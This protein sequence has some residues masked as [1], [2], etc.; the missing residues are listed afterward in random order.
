MSLA[1]AH[2]ACKQRG[3]DSNPGL[4]S[5][6]MLYH[7]KTLFETTIILKSLPFYVFYVQDTDSI[8]CITVLGLMTELKEQCL[9]FLLISTWISFS[10]LFAL[11]RIINTY[12]SRQHSVLNPH[13]HIQLQQ[14]SIYDPSCFIYI[15]IPF[16]SPLPI[17][18]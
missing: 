12:K 5:K 1:I 8:L 9:F 10:F 7:H 16:L 11:W 13:E 6:L 3:W 2:K 14:E 17:L 15:P 4:I 18:F